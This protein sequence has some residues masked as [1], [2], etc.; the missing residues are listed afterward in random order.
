MRP[1][2]A[3]R[4]RGAALL[5]LLAV[6]VLGASWFLVSQLNAESGGITAVKRARNA[7]V[8]NRAKQAL[9]GYIARTAATAGE[10]NPGRLPCPEHAWYIGISDKEGVTGPSV[11][12]SNP[13]FGS[14]DCASIGRLPWRTLGLEKLLDADGEPLWYAVGP[15]WRL[16]NSTSTLVINSNTPGDITVDGQQVVALIIA[17]GAAMN[18]QSATGCTASNQARS[19]PSPT[20]A[21]ANYIECFNSG[22]LQF[23]TTASSASYNDQA[24]RVTVAEIMPAIE[25]V[26]ANRIDREIVPE[27]KKVYTPAMWGFSGSNPVLPFA[28]PFLPDGPGP[29]VGGTSKYLGVAGTYQGLLP[30]NQ[31]QSCT[32][33][34]SDP[35]CT[36]ATTGA[37]AFLVFSK[38]D[39]DVRTAGSGSIGTQSICSW[40]SNTYVCTGEYLLP[41]I[42]VTMTINVTNVAMGLRALDASKVTCQAVD[43]AGAGNPIQTV[44]CTVSAALQSNGSATLTIATSTLPDIA[45]SG[46][47]TNANYKISIDRAAIGDHALLVS[48]NS[49]TGWFVR[50]EWY[51]LLYYS[52]S[53]SNTAAKVA[54]ERSC[55][56]APADCLTIT[57]TPAPS[58]SG[59]AL[60]ILAGRSVNGTSRP[61]ATLADYLEFG[62]AHA[63]FE[64]LTVTPA[65]PILH[66][67]SGAANAYVVST[68]S[69][70]AG[71]TFQFRA[72]NANTGASTVTTP[73]SG[74]RSLVNLDGSNLAASMIQANA[75]VQVTYDGSQFL[76]SKRP[77]NDRIVVVGAN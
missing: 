19:A 6:I 59:A 8:L 28:A 53:Q 21:A 30:F 60:L 4:E 15:T 63:A 43:E 42:S 9:I 7:A 18:A 66:V 73:A 17:P 54:T 61:S 23:V 50:N 65:P 77:F 12:V 71:T 37:T 32:E 13:G 3:R 74:T 56:A 67:D 55:S 11:G 34:A 58:L 36:T 48:T 47:G 68:A 16:R 70:A 33:S 52:T 39:V 25:A 35:R 51:R 69:P 1:V 62:N 46:W 2:N 31:T 64:R 49:T 45:A 40:Q 72:A 14:S 38:S 22:T 75:A 41:S 44:P 27:L 20:M 29:S 76:L 24:M 26:I 5:A 57:A 10:N